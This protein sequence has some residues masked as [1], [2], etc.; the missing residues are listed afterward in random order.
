M[1][2]TAAKTAPPRYG[3]ATVKQ[4]GQFLKCCHVTVYAMIKTGELP[5]TKI[6]NA[7]RVPWAALHK[8]AD[9]AMNT[10]SSAVSDPPA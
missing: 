8:L 9:D 10:G 7:R 5:S 1:T 4:S 6:R 3:F 2:T